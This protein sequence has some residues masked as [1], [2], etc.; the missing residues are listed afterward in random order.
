MEIALSL[1]KSTQRRISP[2]FFLT[3]TT[4]DAYGLLDGLIIPA[5]SHASKHFFTSDCN[6]I[7]ICLWGKYT[8]LSV[9]V[10]ILCFNQSQN[11]KSPS[12]KENTD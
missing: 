9:V 12:Y 8:G 11:P 4:C 6:W 2:V 3:I 1:R 5:L 10:G 7:G